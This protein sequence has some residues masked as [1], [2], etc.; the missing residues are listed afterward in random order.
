MATQLTPAQHA[1]NAQRQAASAARWARASMVVGVG[2]LAL[3]VAGIGLSSLGH[4]SVTTSGPCA[5]VFVDGATLDAGAKVACTGGG[6]VWQVAGAPCADGATWL[7]ILETADPRS[8][9]TPGWALSG[10]AWHATAKPSADLNAATALTI[11]AP[12]SRP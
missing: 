3:V 6:K 9:V 4:H 5:R 10:G 12:T 2:A 8:G 7:Y 11:C 1:A